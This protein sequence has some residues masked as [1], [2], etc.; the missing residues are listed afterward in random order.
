MPDEMQ[1]NELRALRALNDC[2]GAPSGGESLDQRRFKAYV[3]FRCVERY[4]IAKALHATNQIHPPASAAA[5]KE[6]KP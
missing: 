3:F 5:A 1:M 2:Y 6:T 4:S